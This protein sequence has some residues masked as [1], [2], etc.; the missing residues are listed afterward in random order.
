MRRRAIVS[1]VLLAGLVAGD[2]L[3]WRWA[4]A[5]L[6]SGYADWLT[7]RRAEGWV[8]TADAPVRGGWP[9]AAR[10]DIPRMTVAGGVP[11]QPAA[12]SWTAE[13][14]ALIV[15]PTAPRT[16]N[17]SFGG[18]QRIRLAAAPEIG[19]TAERM[20]ATTPLNPATPEA[21]GMDVEIGNL[22]AALATGNLTV[23]RLQLHGDASQSFSL[24]A[25]DIALPPLGTGG[26]WPLGPHIASLVISGRIIGNLPLAPALSTKAVAW[27]DAGGKV[28]L[29]HASI[30]WGPLGVTGQGSLELD[31]R[32]QPMG[33]ATLRI[34]GYDQALDAMARGGSL[35]PRVAAAAKAVLDLI[36]HTPDGGGAPLVDAPLTLRDGQLTVGQIPVARLPPLVWPDAQ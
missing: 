35:P 15:A 32:I 8:I 13:H 18:Q 16:L 28:E 30:G 20:N 17:I 36:A 34:V 31:E 14:V 11:G 5:R 10:L 23:T 2:M 9:L 22:R 1:L 27:R 26:T 3:A 12:M 4:E 25:G 6:E 7:A 24:S 19:F 29:Q 21:A 33:T